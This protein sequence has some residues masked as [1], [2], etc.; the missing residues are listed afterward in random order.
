M[1]RCSM[2]FGGVSKVEW[3]RLPAGSK[4]LLRAF[5]QPIYLPDLTKAFLKN[6]ITVTDILDAVMLDIGLELKSVRDGFIGRHG[7]FCY[8]FNDSPIK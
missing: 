6:I 5:N 3:T 4:S 7:E 2:A 8:D 1:R